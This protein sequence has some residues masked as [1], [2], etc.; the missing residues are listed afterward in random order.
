MDAFADWFFVAFWV[1]GVLLTL[2]PFVPATLVILFG[3]L[4]HELLVGFRE[5]SLGTWLGLGALALLA[6]LLDN[7]AALVG[8]RRYGAGRAG[9]WGAFFGGRFGA[10]LRGGGGLG[11]PFPPRL[12]L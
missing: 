9:L 4:V 1:L 12:A 3:A 8:A 2:L 6:M 11:P 10:L 5:L 7:V